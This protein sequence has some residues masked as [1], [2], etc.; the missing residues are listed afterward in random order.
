M[1]FSKE[2][3]IRFLSQIAKNFEEQPG[4]TELSMVLKLYQDDSDFILKNFRAL[5]ILLNSMNFLSPHG[6]IFRLIREE[7]GPTQAYFCL[8]IC[9][10]FFI[11][12]IFET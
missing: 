6:D 10:R 11:R 9:Q 12:T 5:S 1:I 2:Q 7:L 4:H 8:S 3:T